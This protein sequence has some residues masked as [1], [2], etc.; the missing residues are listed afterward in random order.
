MT[1]TQIERLVEDIEK[2]LIKGEI[3]LK[4]EQLSYPYVAGYYGSVLNTLCFML[5]Q[6]LK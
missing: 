3:A 1:R 5:K 6:E 4:D 2:S